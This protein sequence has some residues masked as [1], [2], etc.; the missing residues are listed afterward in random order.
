MNIIYDTNVIVDILAYREPFYADSA[1]SL[2]IADRK[3]VFSFITSNTVTDIAYILARYKRSDEQVKQAITQLF[4]LVSILDVNSSDCYEAL[5]SK[6]PDFEDAL[7]S[8]C[9]A[10]HGMDYIVTRDITDFEN[11]TIKPIKPNEL[12]TLI[13]NSDFGLLW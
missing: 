2:A 10:R 13:K 3:N 6:I 7:L 8:C 4:L 11:S 5:Q 9:A 1:A 12:Q